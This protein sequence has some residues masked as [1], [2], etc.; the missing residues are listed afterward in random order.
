MNMN[1]LLTG[2]FT[3]TQEQFKELRSLG[4]DIFFIQDESKEMPLP[5]DEID[6]VVCNGLFLHRDIQT[7]TRLRLIQLTSAGLDRVPIEKIRARN[8][9][10]YNA[11]GVYNIPMAEWVFFRVLEHYKQ[12]EHFVRCQANRE[13]VKN[14]ELREISGRKVAIVG[15]G[16]VGQEVAKR[17]SA[18]GAEVTSF[19]IH[20]HK[21]PYFSEMHLIQELESFIMVF[22]IIV[23][24]AP[25]SEQTYH[26]LTENLLY[27]LKAHAVLVNISR[28]GLIDEKALYRV[29]S[30]RTDIY[31]ILDVFENEPLPV[32]SELWKM[33]NVAI[34]PHNSFVSDGNAGRMFELI[35]RNLVDFMEHVL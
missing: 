32:E 8:I 1:L 14:R 28:G 2:A 26:L 18:F 29:L 19:D 5:A 31:A 22:D 15:A 4:Y 21:I 25:L 11:R 16:S 7:F 27:K 9:F 10:L 33:P 35:Y 17:F 3:Y 34:S 23:I 13:W 6:A 24:T 12:A 30:N 20:T